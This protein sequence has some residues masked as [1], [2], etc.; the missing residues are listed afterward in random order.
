MAKSK[1]DKSKE[2]A[3]A[4]IRRDLTRALQLT[5]V[6]GRAKFYD[7][8]EIEAAFEAVQE[9]VYHAFEAFE[10]KFPA[11]ENAA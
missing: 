8:A 6:F 11:K 7:E 1:T 5:Y 2:Y 9:F 10:D 4:D 3:I